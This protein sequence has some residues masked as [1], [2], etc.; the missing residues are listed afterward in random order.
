M[1]IL[2]ALI[3]KD[4]DVVLTEYTEYSGNFQQITRALLRKVHTN[5]KYTIEYDKYKYQ[6]DSRFHSVTAEIVIYINRTQPR[7]QSKKH[8]MGC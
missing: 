1:S 5:T 8:I 7:K 6:Q 4:Q 2:Y 3:S